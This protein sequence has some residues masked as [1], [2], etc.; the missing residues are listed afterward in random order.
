MPDPAAVSY[1]EVPVDTKISFNEGNSIIHVSK[2]VRN[3]QDRKNVSKCAREYRCLHY[4]KLTFL[5]LS[6]L[7]TTETEDRLIAA[8][9]NIGEIRIPNQGKRAPAATGTPD[10]L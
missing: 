3:I 8:A 1:C 4:P 7:L 5:S 9:A 10:A 2:S 6:A